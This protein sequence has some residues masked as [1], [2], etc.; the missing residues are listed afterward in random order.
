MNSARQ[1]MIQN[2]RGSWSSLVIERIKS[3]L[4]IRNE[5]K[6]MTGQADRARRQNIYRR[7]TEGQKRELRETGG[8]G[9]I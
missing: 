9:G 4:K 3:W 1:Y 6:W 7:L 8:I 2:Q 5:R